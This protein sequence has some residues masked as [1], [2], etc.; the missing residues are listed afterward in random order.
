[1][2]APAQ[3]PRVTGP[4]RNRALAAA[5]KAR[6]VELRTAGWTY[7]EI[8][9]ELG[10]K[11]RGAVYNIVAAAL[12]A[13]TIDAVAALQHLEATRLD[14]LQ[15]A[16]WNKAMDGD[17]PAVAAIVRIIQARCRLYGLTGHKS[18]QAP[19]RARTVVTPPAEAS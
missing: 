18:D 10:Y 1:M 17:L 4:H 5:R 15:L 19:A 16:L 6:A 13:N 14:A 7:Q 8:A 3:I 2:S 11:N 9:D 12:K